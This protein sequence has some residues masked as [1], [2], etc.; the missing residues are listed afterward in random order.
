MLFNNPD[1]I[2]NS[3]DIRIGGIEVDSSEICFMN[4][5]LKV[6]QRMLKLVCSYVKFLMSEGVS[7]KEAIKEALNDVYGYLYFIE[8]AYP[9]TEEGIVEEIIRSAEYQNW[10]T[11]IYYRFMDIHF[12]VITKETPIPVSVESAISMPVERFEEEEDETLWTLLEALTSANI[13]D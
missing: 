11:N 4:Y 13:N 1:I 2:K 7:H 8:K 10:E 12:G 3:A 6:R 5:K 9:D